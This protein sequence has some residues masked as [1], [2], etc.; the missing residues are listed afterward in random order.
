MQI[1][2]A[3]HFANERCLCLKNMGGHKGNTVWKKLEL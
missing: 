3:I 2:C 1:I